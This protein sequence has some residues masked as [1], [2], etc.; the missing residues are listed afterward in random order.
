M[1]VKEAALA[2]SERFGVTFGEVGQ[3][4]MPKFRAELSRARAVAGDW[5]EKKKGL[6][7]ALLVG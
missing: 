5:D 6:E 3:R 4:P 1:S 2:H 7:E